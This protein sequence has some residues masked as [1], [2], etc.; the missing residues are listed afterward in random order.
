MCGSECARASACVSEGKE[1]E[2]ESP[3]VH[4]NL[5]VRECV[6]ACSYADGLAISLLQAHH[7]AEWAAL[8]VDALQAKRPSRPRARDRASPHKLRTFLEHPAASAAQLSRSGQRIWL[9][10]QIVTPD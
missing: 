2:R 3:F 9:A 5:C 6:C 1:G 4:V 8:P 10:G 7:L